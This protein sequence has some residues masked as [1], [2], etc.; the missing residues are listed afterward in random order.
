MDR[1]KFK[2][3]E[4]SKNYIALLHE[5]LEFNNHSLDKCR[6]QIQSDDYAEVDI[7]SV[8]TL[9]EIKQEMER[10]DIENETIVSMIKQNK[11]N[12]RLINQSKNKTLKKYDEKAFIVKYFHNQKE[13]K[14]ER[15]LTIG[16]EFL[17]YKIENIHYKIDKDRLKICVEFSNESI[18]AL[19]IHIDGVSEVHRIERHKL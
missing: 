14:D 7:I 8:R 3:I 12:L 1:I 9:A 16:E 11:V 18:R 2:E 17:G 4:E 13:R 15:V 6:A 19:S 10:V 5:E